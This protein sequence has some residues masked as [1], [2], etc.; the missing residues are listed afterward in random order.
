M[1]SEF[2]SIIHSSMPYC[3]NLYT[4]DKILQKRI[5]GAA[6]LWINERKKF[7]GHFKIH[8]GPGS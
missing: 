6:A 3:S 4:V 1:W 2:A 5:S 8:F 7:N